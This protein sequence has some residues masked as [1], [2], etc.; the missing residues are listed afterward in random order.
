MNQGAA[1][2]YFVKLKKNASLGKCK[3][4]FQLNAHKGLSVQIK[5]F[6]VCAAADQT[7]MDLLLSSVIATKAFFML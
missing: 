7:D 1:M 2:S 5:S 4:T 3:D 6:C